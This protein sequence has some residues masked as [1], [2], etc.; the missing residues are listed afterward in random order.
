MSHLHTGAQ[1]VPQYLDP[2][3]PVRF[4]PTSKQFVNPV[5]NQN[6]APCLCLYGGAT[7]PEPNPSRSKGGG[8]RDAS[9]RGQFKP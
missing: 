7:I 9:V 6:K 8:T 2:M 1:K 3:Q 4:Y 5:E